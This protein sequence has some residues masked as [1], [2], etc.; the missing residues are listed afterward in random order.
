MT[1]FITAL[2]LADLF[3]LGIVLYFTIESIREKERRA[4]R[5]ERV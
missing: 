3:F 1:F 4:P 2:L 5:V